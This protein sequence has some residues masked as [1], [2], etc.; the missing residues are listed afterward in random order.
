MVPEPIKAASPTSNS[1]HHDEV[2]DA[3][4]IRDKLQ[5]RRGNF[6]KFLK[7][8]EAAVRVGTEV[9][10]SRLTWKVAWSEYSKKWVPI[11]TLMVPDRLST[12]VV[13]VEYRLA[14]DEH[15][16][17]CGLDTDPVGPA[18][19]LLKIDVFNEAFERGFH[20]RKYVGIQLGK[21]EC[22]EAVVALRKGIVP[23]YL[24][25]RLEQQGHPDMYSVTE[26]SDPFEDIRRN[27]RD[28]KSRKPV[29]PES[30]LYK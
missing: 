29:S 5:S 10:G 22:E 27:T 30:T 14:Y 2:S 17:P 3:E 1:D 25:E 9:T 28:S 8:A 16:E 26:D 24:L 7:D 21:K 23:A 15:V 11:F 19:R 18:Y 6:E 13:M 4:A 12:C 20:R